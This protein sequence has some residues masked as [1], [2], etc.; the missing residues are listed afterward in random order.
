M[1]EGTSKAVLR[2][3]RKIDRMIWRQEFCKKWEWEITIVI[4][5]LFFILCIIVQCVAS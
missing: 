3:I 2:E 4:S 5:L 1:K